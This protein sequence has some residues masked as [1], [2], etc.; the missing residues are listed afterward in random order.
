[1][2]VA[3]ATLGCRVNKYET[4]AM[5][6]KFIKDGYKV[7]PFEEYADVY[8]INTCTVTNMG[9]KKSRQMIHRAR[10]ENEAAVIAVVGCYSQ[11]A[12]EEVSQI[13]GVDVVLGTRNKG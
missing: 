4:E 7:V 9:D 8:V 2:K 12:S 11:I 1:M 6:E 13:D 10:R 3:F 5:V